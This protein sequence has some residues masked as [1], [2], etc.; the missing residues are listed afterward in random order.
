MP[1]CYVNILLQYETVR[2]GQT[3]NTG[4][5]LLQ[6]YTFTKKKK[7]KKNCQQNSEI[8]QTKTTIAWLLLPFPFTLFI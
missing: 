7:K 1:I 8:G 2:I 3:K 5:N 4:T 6:L